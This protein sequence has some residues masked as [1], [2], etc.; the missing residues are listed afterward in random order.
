[1]AAPIVPLAPVTV[2]WLKSVALTLA[3]QFPNRSA[4]VSETVTAPN[5]VLME[6]PGAPEPRFLL[7]GTVM[8]RPLLSALTAK[9]VTVSPVVA[10]EADVTVPA[11]AAKVTA[12]TAMN[13]RIRLL[14]P[15]SAARPTSMVPCLRVPAFRRVCPFR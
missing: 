11:S 1:M 7:T 15:R 8:A 3:V 4:R 12:K 9:V 6:L 5:V 13:L 14:F 10:A 2:A